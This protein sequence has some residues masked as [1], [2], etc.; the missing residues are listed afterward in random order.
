MRRGV[1]VG[2]YEPITTFSQRCCGERYA[3]SRGKP[4]EPT[5]IQERALG[6][7]ISGSH[8]KSDF[9]VSLI[10]KEVTLTSSTEAILD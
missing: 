9:F 2:S 10:H 1:T 8:L 3:E 6:R 4:A 5:V 7:F